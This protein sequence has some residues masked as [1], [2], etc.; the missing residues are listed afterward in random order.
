MAHVDLRAESKR[1]WAAHLESAPDEPTGGALFN[2]ANPLADAGR[3]S[4]FVQPYERTKDRGKGGFSNLRGDVD[5]LAR[6]NKFVGYVD[7]ADKQKRLEYFKNAS[8]GAEFR[9]SRYLP[10]YGNDFTSKRPS[11]HRKYRIP[12]TSVVNKVSDYGWFFGCCGWKL[13]AVCVRNSNIRR[14]EPI[15]PSAVLHAG[16]IHL[17]G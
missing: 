9:Q 7:E 8:K 6:N 4:E 13:T 17:V 3:G 14:L 5:F 2:R 10:V 12:A 15:C 16:P 11:S 1:R